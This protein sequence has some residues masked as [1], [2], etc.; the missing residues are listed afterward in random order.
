MEQNE[1]LLTE[2]ESYGK[3]GYE[4]MFRILKDKYK[5]RPGEAIRRLTAQLESTNHVIYQELED[6]VQ[7]PEGVR[8]WLPKKRVDLN[9]LGRDLASREIYDYFIKCKIVTDYRLSSV[10]RT[11]CAKVDFMKIWR[12]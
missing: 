11:R 12:S 7:D 1:N 4:W 10:I 3:I 6:G 8:G 2:G 9:N 5:E